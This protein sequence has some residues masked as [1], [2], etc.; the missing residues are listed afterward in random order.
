MIFFEKYDDND[1][2]QL[3]Y[4]WFDEDERNKEHSLHESW[5][6]T[7]I[8]CH[9]GDSHSHFFTHTVWVILI[10]VNVSYLCFCLSI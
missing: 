3:I 1:L 10:D 8:G 4:G 6:T 2:K 7:L 9:K 5:S